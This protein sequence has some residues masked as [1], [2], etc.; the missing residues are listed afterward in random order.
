MS[1]EIITLTFG[2]MAENHKGMEKIGQLVKPG[3]GFQLPDLEHIKN[4]TE[5]MGATSTIVKLSTGDQPEAYVL[6][7][8][9]GVNTLLKDLGYDKEALYKENK[10]LKWDSQALMYGRVVNKAARHNLCYDEERREPDYINGKGRIVAYNEVPITNMLKKQ[11]EELFGAKARNLKIEGNYYYD[12]R[13]CGIGFHSDLERRKVIGVR[14]G[15][16]SSPLHFNWFYKSEPVGE[17]I[18]IPLDPG[19]IYVMQE[20]AVGTDGRKRTIPILRHSTGADKYTT[21]PVKKPLTRDV[22]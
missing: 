13:K 2:D 11:F 12:I 7:I 8:K 9:D 14:L 6:V 10:L 1:K 18:T 4:V 20:K 16:A 19:D 15:N 21:V 22:E 5:R 17:R 3:D